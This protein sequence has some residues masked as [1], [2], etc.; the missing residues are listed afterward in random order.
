MTMDISRIS[1]NWGRPGDRDLRRGKGHPRHRPNAGIHGN[2]GRPR[3]RYG[4]R[5]FRLLFGG[6]R[7]QPRIPGG[8]TEEIARII[9]VQ[10]TLGLVG[11]ILVANP[12]PGNTRFPGKR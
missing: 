2:H 4:P 6:K 3:D 9:S 7:I 10:R 11:G 5:N 12:Y 8:H 1:A